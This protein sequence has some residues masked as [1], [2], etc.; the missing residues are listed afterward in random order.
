M[1]IN[2]L[3]KISNI[4]QKNL[5]IPSDVL[6]SVVILILFETGEVNLLF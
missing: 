6:D 3:P 4:S 2:L 5:I 1:F